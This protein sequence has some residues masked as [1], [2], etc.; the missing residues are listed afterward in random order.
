MRQV[1]GGLDLTATTM[2][3]Y[4]LPTEPLACSSEQSS[5]HCSCVWRRVQV[6]EAALLILAHTHREVD[7]FWLR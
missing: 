6:G 7:Y 2:E 3:L 5:E 4:G 1:L